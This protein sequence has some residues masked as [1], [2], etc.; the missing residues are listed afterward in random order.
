MNDTGTTPAA[1]TDGNYR[2]RG[3]G[4]ASGDEHLMNRA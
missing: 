4:P 1:V 2:R 3:S